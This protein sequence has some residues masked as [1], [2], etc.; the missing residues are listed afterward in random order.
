M[1]HAPLVRWHISLQ[2][3]FPSPE[4]LEATAVPDYGIEGCE[5]AQLVVD[6]VP[7]GRRVLTLRPEPHRAI[8]L[9]ICIAGFSILVNLPHLSRE[10]RHSRAQ[11]PAQIAQTPRRQRRIKLHQHIEQMSRTRDP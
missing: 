9:G 2:L 8:D 1:T 7:R 4:Q 5:E 6:L 3:V 10:M 11:Q